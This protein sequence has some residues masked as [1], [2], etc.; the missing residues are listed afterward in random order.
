[1]GGDGGCQRDINE[2]M[3]SHAIDTHLTGNG[4]IVFRQTCGLEVCGAVRGGVLRRGEPHGGNWTGPGRRGE[5]MAPQPA[6]E[7]LGSWP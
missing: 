4:H 2:K 1:M 7:E 5:K 6:S 3:T